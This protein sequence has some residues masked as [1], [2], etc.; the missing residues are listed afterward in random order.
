LRLVDLESLSNCWTAPFDEQICA[1]SRYNVA[2]D[3]SHTSL[4]RRLTGAT[5]AALIGTRGGHALL[6]Q[7]DTIGKTSF[8]TDIRLLFSILYTC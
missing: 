6:L 7:L 4:Q 8:S 1:L 5:A 2:N 3:T